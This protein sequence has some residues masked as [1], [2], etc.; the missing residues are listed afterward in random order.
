MLEG[1]PRRS[2]CSRARLGRCSKPCG[3]NPMPV[4]SL[5]GQFEHLLSYLAERVHQVTSRVASNAIRQTLN[6]LNHF[7]YPECPHTT[8]ML[9]DFLVFSHI[10]TYVSIYILYIYIINC[11]LTFWSN[12]QSVERRS[13]NFFLFEPLRGMLMSLTSLYNGM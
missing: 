9:L 11:S 5:K 7:S 6:W 13:E 4:F 3:R 1:H 10:F 8:E 12:F 2:T